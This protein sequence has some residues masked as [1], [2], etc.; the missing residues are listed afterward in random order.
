M[1]SFQNYGLRKR[2]LEKCL[3]N[4]ISEDL[5]RDNMV[6]TVSMSTTRPLAYLLITVRVI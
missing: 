2:W 3:K 6:N 4:P 1:M 5:W